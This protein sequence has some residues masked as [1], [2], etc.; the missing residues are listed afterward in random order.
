MIFPAR[1]IG[2]SAVAA[3]HLKSIGKSPSGLFGFHV[4]THLANVPID[5][6][7]SPSWTIF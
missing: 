5:N 7:W 2:A 3:I 4:P 6:K 1:R